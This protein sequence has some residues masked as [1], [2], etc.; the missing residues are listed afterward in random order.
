MRSNE[1]VIGSSDCQGLGAPK[2][3][4]QAPAK[5]VEK[6]LGGGIIQGADG[7]LRTDHPTPIGDWTKVFPHEANK[8]RYFQEQMRPDGSLHL[9]ETDEHGWVEW[10]GNDCPVPA[11]VVVQVRSINGFLV[12]IALTAG[13]WDWRYIDAYRLAYAPRPNLCAVVPGADPTPAAPHQAG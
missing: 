6:A 5:P 10:A 9:V 13:S 4:N 8:P 2:R 3:A 7:R 12:E 11:Q 1:S